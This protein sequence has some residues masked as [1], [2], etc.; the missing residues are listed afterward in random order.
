[1]LPAINCGA[2]F[3]N[4]SLV[5]FSYLPTSNCC[6]C[7][8]AGLFFLFLSAG[9]L[10]RVLSGAPLPPERGVI[11]PPPGTMLN[12]TFSYLSWDELTICF[13]RPSGC[14]LCLD[15]GCLMFEACFST[16]PRKPSLPNEGEC[17]WFGSY[18]CWFVF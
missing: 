18:F 13:Y 2:F 11:Y 16:P 15:G 5:S 8:A 6:S 1:M 14:F 10:S 9:L 17:F 7:P 4:R 12:C 3:C